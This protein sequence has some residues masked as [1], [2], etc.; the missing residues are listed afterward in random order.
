M[1]NNMNDINRAQQRAM[2]EEKRRK[3]RLAWMCWAL[4]LLCLIALLLLLLLPFSKGHDRDNIEYRDTVVH[5]IEYHDTVYIERPVVRDTVRDEIDRRVEQGHGNI[6]AY[7]RFSIL[8]NRSG[9]DIVDLDAHAVEPTGN[10]I[11]Y[12]NPGPSSLRG[13][14]DI[15]RKRPRSEGVENIAWPSADDLADGD[16]QFYIENYD[17]GTNRECIAKLIIG[18]KAFMYRVSNISM[19]RSNAVHI[20]TVT[21]RDH[22]MVNIRHAQQPVN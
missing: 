5:R 18:D 11:F 3:R 2:I 4:G 1:E 9:S 7:M 14:L 6:N 13:K 17:G 12:R 16:Y 15:D 21:I 10:R 22:H 20:A 8:W 19:G